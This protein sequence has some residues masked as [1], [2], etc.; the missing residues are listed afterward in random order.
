MMNSEISHRV[1]DILNF[2]FGEPNN[3]DYGKPRK[4]W[5]IKNPDFDEEVRS[6]FYTD[7]EAAAAG[8][9]DSWQTAP[10]SCLALIILLD[11]LP[12]NLFRG[13]WRSFATDPKAL[14]AAQYA[15]EQGFD[16]QMIPIKRWFIY[17]PY[18]H[19]ENLEHQRQ[20]VALFEQLREDADSASTIDY[21]IRHYQVIEKF[22]RFPHRNQ[23]LGR[24]NT[25]E[26]TEF[27]KQPGSS[28]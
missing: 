13:Q 1:K 19:S 14:S 15:V 28:F 25:P 26:E 18:E 7:Y 10:E 5:F 6:H 22:G 21:A 20:S 17:L 4:I 2:W 16:Q 11:Q 23:I 8:K 3:Q 27:L 24:E 12:R 9:L